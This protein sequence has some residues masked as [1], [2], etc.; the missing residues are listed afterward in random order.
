[1]CFETYLAIVGAFTLSALL[2]RVVDL[3]DGK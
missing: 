3:I 2:M 1:M